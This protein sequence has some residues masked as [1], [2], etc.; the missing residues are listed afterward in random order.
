MLND[1]QEL[2]AQRE[3]LDQLIVSLD[4]PGASMNVA[5]LAMGMMN[6]TASKRKIA[7]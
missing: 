6:P 4:R 7:G 3:R 5:Q 1:P 2:A